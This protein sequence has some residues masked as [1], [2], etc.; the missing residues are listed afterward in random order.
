LGRLAAESP[1]PPAPRAAG[2][3]LAGLPRLLPRRPHLAHARLHRAGGAAM[4]EEGR[5]LT[6]ALSLEADLCVVGTGAGGAMVAR[7]AARAGL[8]V[9]ALEEGPH[10]SPRDFTQREDQMF[11]LLFQD[12]GGRA[13][14]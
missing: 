1:H 5:A 12:A 4:I 10:L 13:T 3:A 14:S 8:R 9:V 2:P 7:Q 11:P 6:R